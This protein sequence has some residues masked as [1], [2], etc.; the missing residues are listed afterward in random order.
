MLCVFSEAFLFLGRV[1]PQGGRAVSSIYL[2]LIA[3]KGRSS[4]KRLM[5]PCQLSGCTALKVVCFARAFARALIVI[6]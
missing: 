4:A 5:R 3:L 1:R 6:F 2:D